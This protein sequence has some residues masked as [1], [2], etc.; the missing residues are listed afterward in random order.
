MT[1]YLSG[2][3]RAPQV[4]CED[5]GYLEAAELLGRGTCLRNA[6]LCELGVVP[7]TLGQA[8]GVPGALAVPDQP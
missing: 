7:V 8:Q 1:E 6:T 2:L 4:A 5:R 3:Q